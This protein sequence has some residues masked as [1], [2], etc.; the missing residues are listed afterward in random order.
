MARSTW[1]TICSYTRG[2]LAAMVRVTVHSNAPEV[3]R[4]RVGQSRAMPAHARLVTILAAGCASATCAPSTVVVERKEER[5][6]VRTE[7]RG[8]RTN[9][10]G[11]VV[12]D[13]RDVVVPEYW[14][15]ARDGRWYIVSESEWQAAE[16]GRALSLCR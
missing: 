10:T 3:K 15:Q 9:A 5:P 13:R 12:E 2:A 4:G 16:P 7:T 14:V 1:A 6:R 11:R 8:V